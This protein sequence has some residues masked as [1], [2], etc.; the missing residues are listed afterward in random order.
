M[1]TDPRPQG[2]DLL[3][4]GGL[5]VDRFADGPSGPGG[6]VLHVAR[7]AKRRGIALGVRTSAGPEPEAVAGVAELHR[8]AERV[9]VARHATTATFRHR[10]SVEGRRLWLERAGGPVTD[11]PAASRDAAA[12][13]YA[14]VF[15]EVAA[16]AIAA[17]ASAS[18]GAEGRSGRGA[19]LQGWLR[20]AAED[21]EVHPLPLATLAP[22]LRD[23][24]AGLDLLVASHEDLRADGATASEQLVSLRGALG[25]KPVLVLTVGDDGLWLDSGAGG[26]HISVPRRVDVARAVGAGDVLAAFLLIGARMPPGGWPARAEEAMS[27]VADELELRPR[28]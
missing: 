19:I 25:P 24:L 26:L 28:S 15:D 3:V 13:L 20:R 1:L 11:G 7:A 8:L 27:V 6:S 21:D 12:V 17:S 10:E 16:T 5:T 22:P 9:D 2:L 18:A 14:P 4:V 23:A